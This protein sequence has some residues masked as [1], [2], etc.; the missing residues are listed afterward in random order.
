M[1]D[2]NN[3]KALTYVALKCFKALQRFNGEE[4]ARDQRLMQILLS[5]WKDP[6]FVG[7]VKNIFDKE[8]NNFPYWRIPCYIAKLMIHRTKYVAKSFIELEALDEKDLEAKANLEES[9][10]LIFNLL[11]CFDNHLIY[12]FHEIRVFV[13]DIVVKTYPIVWLRNAF[14]KFASIFGKNDYSHEFKAR[15]VTH[16]LIPGFV[17]AFEN[18]KSE[19]LIGGKPQPELDSSDNVISVFLNNVGI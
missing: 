18:G 6:S 10:E 12:Q 17:Q 1:L 3:S 14:F 16:L 5:I 11:S 7:H 8:N 9:I 13:D 19:Q 15:I 4:L 2:M